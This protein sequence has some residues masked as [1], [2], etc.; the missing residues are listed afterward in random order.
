MT[1]IDNLDYMAS[2]S[3]S[4]GQASISLTFTNKANPDVAQDAGAEQTAAR[5]RRNCRRSV[6]NTGITVSKSTSNFLMVIGFISTDGKLNSNDL[7]DYVN[8]TLNDTLKRVE[9][10]G[11]T[12]LFG[13][14]YAMRIWIDPDKLAKYQLMTS[15]VVSAIEAQNTQV[16]TGQL[17][18]LPQLQGQQL[19]ATV[20]AKS[21]LQTP[22][23]FNN[24]ILKSQ[25]DGSLVRLNDVARASN[26]APDSY[27]SSSCL[28]QS[29]VGGSRGQCLPPALTLSIRPKPCSR[30]STA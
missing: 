10:V 21:R 7:A 2:T 11:D 13:A 8:S 23:Q 5:H 17:G 20:T 30:R 18:A 16:S 22:E 28:Q 4:T 26:W 12:Q 14:G 3:T 25:S 29:A 6:Q 9:G 15:D 19:N 1:G 24:I 27:T